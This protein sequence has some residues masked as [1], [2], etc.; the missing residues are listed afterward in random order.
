MAWRVCSSETD[1]SIRRARCSRHRRRRRYTC[2]RRSGVVWVRRRA[3]HPAIE[4]AEPRGREGE[5]VDLRRL[6]RRLGG[7]DNTGRI[8]NLRSPS[9]RSFVSDRPI[10]ILLIVLASIVLRRRVVF[11]PSTPTFLPPLSWGHRGLA[12]GLLSVGQKRLETISSVSTIV[13]RAHDGAGETWT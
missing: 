9:T 1:C 3:E 6:G 8:S 12:G 2:D 10:G 13:W 5:E 4:T 11:L 7:G